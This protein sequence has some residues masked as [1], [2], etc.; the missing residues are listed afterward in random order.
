[1]KNEY[2]DEGYGDWLTSNEGIDNTT[3]SNMN[4]MNKKIEEKKTNLK[5]LIVHKDIQMMENNNNCSYLTNS[6]PD[7]YSSDVFSK[8]PFED[9]KKAHTETVVPVNINDYHNRTKFNSIMN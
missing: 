2:S 5:S 9:I 1:M 4:E 8:L 3:I 7:E 6:K